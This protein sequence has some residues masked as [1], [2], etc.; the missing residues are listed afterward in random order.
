M[1]EFLTLLK[2]VPPS[3]NPVHLLTELGSYK[4]VFIEWLSRGART[5]I[6]GKGVHG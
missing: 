3:H 2:D 5:E 6:T 1:Q 4:L